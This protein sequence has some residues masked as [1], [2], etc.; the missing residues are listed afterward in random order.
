[1]SS[2]GYQNWKKLEGMYVT[3]AEIMRSGDRTGV[4]RLEGNYKLPVFIRGE[5]D[6]C[7][8]TWIEDVVN[9]DALRQARIETVVERECPDKK[10][11]RK[12][13]NVVAFYELVITT[14]RGVAVVDYRNESNGYYGG[15][16]VVSD[17]K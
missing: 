9:I 2:Y 13:F 14:S 17:R 7:S 10:E 3:E 16:L 1:M 8:H 4:L 12:E 5:G 6:C 15:W 11:E